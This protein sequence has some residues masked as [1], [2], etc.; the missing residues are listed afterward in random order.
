MIRAVI[1][2]MDGVISDTQT[3]YSEVESGVLAR[4]GIAISPDEITK[5]YAGVS[6]HQMFGELL[7]NSETGVNI[8]AVVQ[9]TRNAMEAR[10]QYAPILPIG[11][12]QELVYAFHGEGIK[13]AVASSSRLRFIDRVLTELG[14]KNKFHAVASGEEVARGKPAPDIFLL[15]ASRLGSAASE[16][17]VIEDGISGMIGAKSAGMKCIGLVGDTE[18]DYPVDMLV[19]DLRDITLEKINML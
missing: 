14:L 11:G 5:K 4:Y 9:E 17:V 8:E 6:D 19:K 13:L 1:F 7:D 10:L 18:G 2:D 12:T 3:I 16:C 15:A